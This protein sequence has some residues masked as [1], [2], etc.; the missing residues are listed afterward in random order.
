MYTRYEYDDAGR[1]TAVYKESSQYGTGGEVKISEHN[2][3]Y[4]N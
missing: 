1:V 2:Y 4:K 3:N